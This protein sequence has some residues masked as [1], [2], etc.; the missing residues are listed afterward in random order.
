MEIPSWA[1][2]PWIVPVLI[3]GL[4][5]KESVEL[6]TTNSI[7]T[8]STYVLA[9]GLVASGLADADG[10]FEARIWRSQLDPRFRRASMGAPLRWRQFRGG[11]GLRVSGAS[12]AIPVQTWGVAHT[13]SPRR[14]QDSGDR[15][16]PSLSELRR[17]VKGEAVAQAKARGWVRWQ[18]G[19]VVGVVVAMLALLSETV[20]RFAADDYWQ[21]LT[22]DSLGFLRNYQ[23]TT[24][25]ITTV[26]ITATARAL[27]LPRFDGRRE[28]PTLKG[29]F[30]R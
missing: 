2:R 17:Y 21:R 19:F 24:I 5:P 25:V 8:D 28:P 12:Y 23:S 22:A 1:A 14:D 27:L 7:E 30:F 6:F 20:L 10:C 16:D 13:L 9:G 26:L 18:A 15:A 11:V 3:A 29:Q 4:R